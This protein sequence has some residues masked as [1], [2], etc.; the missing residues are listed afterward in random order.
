MVQSP[1]GERSFV[2]VDGPP[3]GLHLRFVDRSTSRD[4]SAWVALY[5]DP[6]A[7]D[8]LAG[9]IV[10]VVYSVGSE[11]GYG[12]REG[13][14]GERWVVLPTAD[15]DQETD[16]VVVGGR[17]LD[18][19]DLRGL[20]ERVAL[21]DPAA[22]GDEDAGELRRAHLAERDLAADR[23][24]LAEGPI[25]LS[26]V[27]ST[28]EGLLR[29][30]PAVQWDSEDR[31]R[32]VRVSS[33]DVDPAT[34]LLVRSIVDDPEGTPLRGTVGAL[35]P[36][37]AVQREGGAE[38]YLAVWEE[39]GLLTVAQSSGLSERTLRDFVQGLRLSTDDDWA[40]L[41]D[42]AEQSP[43]PAASEALLA[44]GNFDGARWWISVQP[45]SRS[46]QIDLWIE[47]VDGRS[48]D[49][50]PAGGCHGYAIASLRGQT[51]TVVSGLAPQGAASV[52]LEQ[53]GRAPIVVMTSPL[54]AGDLVFWNVAVDD[55][56]E[57]SAV[58]FRDVSGG[59][60]RRISASDA[61][62]SGLVPGSGVCR[63]E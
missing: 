37:S 7:P 11:T 13:P 55:E 1:Q 14:A 23:V 34:S 57:L 62:T 8:P 63:P 24:L 43:P 44:S 32:S 29:G 20:A 61:D 60:L 35:G 53:A 3:S 36:P 30:G 33:I 15:D 56:V 49:Q 21:A 59:V 39:A 17:G 40:H 51:G 52:A 42:E 25:D 16:Q 45:Y 22:V 54:P 41:T 47:A 2:P 31:E 19:R 38:V 12:W 50:I 26:M 27:W 46:E 9:D 58:E 6:A 5:G 10:H 28:Y 18:D 48:F 4:P